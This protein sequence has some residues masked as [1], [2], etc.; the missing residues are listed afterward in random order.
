MSRD[1]ITISPHCSFSLFDEICSAV[2]RI[3]KNKDTKAQ[4]NALNKRIKAHKC[5][6]IHQERREQLIKILNFWISN[7]NRDRG[8]LKP[9]LFVVLALYSMGEMEV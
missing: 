1:V 2:K 3:E 6:N 7:C 5:T 9:Y 8:V 4:L